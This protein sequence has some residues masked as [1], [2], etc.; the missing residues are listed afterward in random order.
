[1][2][3]LPRLQRGTA[4]AQDFPTFSNPLCVRRRFA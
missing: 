2:R 1:M 4:A 3:L